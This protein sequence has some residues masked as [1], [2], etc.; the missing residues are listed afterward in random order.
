MQYILQ[1]ISLTSHCKYQ[2]K[3]VWDQRKLIYKEVRLLNLQNSKTETIKDSGG[4]VL[5][6]L[7][8]GRVRTFDR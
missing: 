5:A 1:W 7:A 6:N 3:I 8:R 2:A 4:S